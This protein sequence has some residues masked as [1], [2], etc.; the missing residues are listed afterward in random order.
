MALAYVYVGDIRISVEGGEP[1]VYE[2]R[3]LYDEDQC[4]QNVQI[5]KGRQWVD[6]TL[7]LAESQIRNVEDRVNIELA[8]TDNCEAV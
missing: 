8:C 4:V 5:A 1:E 3:A 2:A 6:M 7:L